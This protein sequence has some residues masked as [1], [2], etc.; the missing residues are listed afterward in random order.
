MSIERVR[1]WDK[2]EEDET[3]GFDAAQICLN[4]HAINSAVKS[5]PQF[6]EKFCKNCGEHTIQ[7]CPECQ[8]EIRGYYIG[9]LSTAAYIPPRFCHDCGK[10]YPW[11]SCRLEAVKAYAQ[12]LQAL[13]PEEGV[14]LAVSL[15]ELVNDTPMAQVAAGRFKRL[16]TKAGGEAPGFSKE[17]LA[18]L[19]SETVKKAIWGPTSA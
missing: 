17:M 1:G 11:T 9:S 15:D 8:T 5:L 10:P 19:V 7:T 16:V 6:S 2:D 18:Y 14:Q 3:E 13:T 12:E 4:G